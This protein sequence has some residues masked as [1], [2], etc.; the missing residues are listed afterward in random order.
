[1]KATEPPDYCS[2][3]RSLGLRFG[4]DRAGTSKTSCHR[5][6]Q[7][8]LGLVRGLVRVVHG[9]DSAEP[10]SRYAPGSSAHFRLLP[11]GRLDHE[12]SRSA[13]T[14]H[15]SMAGECAGRLATQSVKTTST[16]CDTQTGHGNRSEPDRAGDPAALL[17]RRLGAAAWSS[18]RTPRSHGERTATWAE[19]HCGR[20]DQ[21]FQTTSTGVVLHDGIGGDIVAELR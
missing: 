5:P 1:M 15:I 14:L 20:T 16:D 18:T 4:H 6:R 3:C 2:R 11:S 21:T 19:H 10:R 7:H 9:V 8:S 17:H 13:P 12:N